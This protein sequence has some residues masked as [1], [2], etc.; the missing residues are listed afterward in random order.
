MSGGNSP[1]CFQNVNK[2]HLLFFTLLF[3]SFVLIFKVDPQLEA[4]DQVCEQQNSNVGK[5]MELESNEDVSVIVSGGNSP[6][7]IQNV[8][9]FCC[10]L[11]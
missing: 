1:C 11:S 3:H 2:F 6:R 9:N 10:I 4:N 8:N 5:E 7:C